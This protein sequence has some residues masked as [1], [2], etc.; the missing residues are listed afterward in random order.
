MCVIRLTGGGKKEKRK[1][2]KKKRN[3]EVVMVIIMISTYDTAE[4]Q[5]VIKG[6]Q[7]KQQ[8]VCDSLSSIYG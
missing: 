2:G 1:K 6:W 3:M 5:T 8:P 7:E 4:L